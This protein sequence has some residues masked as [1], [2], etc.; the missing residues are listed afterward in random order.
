MYNNHYSPKPI[1][2]ERGVL[3]FV[4][5]IETS[6]RYRKGNEKAINK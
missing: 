5:I 3:V 6:Q 4:N 2:L 1:L